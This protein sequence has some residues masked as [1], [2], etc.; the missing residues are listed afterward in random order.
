MADAASPDVSSISF[1][2]RW[3]SGRCLISIKRCLANAA[4]NSRHNTGINIFNALL[5]IITK[6]I[7]QK[8]THIIMGRFIYAFKLTL[9]S[10]AGLKR[11]LC[12]NSFP[13]LV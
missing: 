6:P 10:F 12:Q 4:I 3:L 11:A 5:L 7:K 8:T 2:N 9:K 1:E 13:H